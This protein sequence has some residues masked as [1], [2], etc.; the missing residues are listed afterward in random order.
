MVQAWAAS[1]SR[2]ATSVLNFGDMKVPEHAQLLLLKVAGRSVGGVGGT[3]VQEL[4]RQ[5]VATESPVAIEAGVFW[6]ELEFLRQA[7]DAQHPFQADY[8]VHRPTA[9]AIA[10]T[11]QLG[12]AGV[13]RSRQITLEK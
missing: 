11:L 1:R 2:R 12:P 3:D 4:L 9:R 5:A 7:A 13:K 10:R 6:E 8:P